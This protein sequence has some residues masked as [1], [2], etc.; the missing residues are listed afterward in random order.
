MMQRGQQ[1]VLVKIGH[2]VGAVPDL[3]FG[4]K[5]FR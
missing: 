5:R 2:S 3:R 1:C 4:E